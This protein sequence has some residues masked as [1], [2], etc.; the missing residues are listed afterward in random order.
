MRESTVARR[1]LVDT[2][3]HATVGVQALGTTIRG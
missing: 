3:H 2:G 1:E